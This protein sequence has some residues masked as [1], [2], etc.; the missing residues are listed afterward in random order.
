M[1]SLL[2]KVASLGQTFYFTETGLNGRC[3]TDALLPQNTS[4]QLLLRTNT[5]CI[6]NVPRKYWYYFPQNSILK[7]E[8]KKTGF[9][10]AQTEATA[11]DVLEKLILKISE[12]S[13]KAIYWGVHLLKYFS[14]YTCNFTKNRPLVMHFLK[15]INT[16][17]E[18]NFLK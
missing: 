10:I 3:F 11:Q 6:E 1:K 15:S 12:N 9:L 18:S 2:P 17:F 7:A 13:N 8:D 5:S 14:S 4:R 16:C